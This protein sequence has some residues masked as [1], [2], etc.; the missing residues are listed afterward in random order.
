MGPG[1]AIDAIDNKV[2]SPMDGY[3][4]MMFPTKH[5]FCIVD[6]HRNE[7]FIQIGTDSVEVNGEGFHAHRITG[8]SVKRGELLIEFD[9][10]VLEKAHLDH[11]VVMCMTQLYAYDAILKDHNDVTARRSDVLELH[12]RK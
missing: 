10:D 1:I 6:D 9:Q 12:K 11:H 8:D 5:A 2:Y 3:I 7:C 4:K